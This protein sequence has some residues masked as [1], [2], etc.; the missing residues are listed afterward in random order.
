MKYLNERFRQG[1]KFGEP[2]TLID[3]AETENKIG[4]SK[5][6]GSLHDPRAGT[7]HPLAYCRGLARKAKEMGA[8]IYEKSNLLTVKKLTLKMT[9]NTDTIM[10]KKLLGEYVF[11]QKKYPF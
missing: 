10:L 6:L 1:E 5:F 8:K 4:S 3:K 2:L 7:I 11:E 9:L